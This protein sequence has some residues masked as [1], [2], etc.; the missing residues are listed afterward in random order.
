MVYLGIGNNELKGG[1]NQS[2]SGFTFPIA[3]ATVDIDGKTIVRNGQLVSTAVASAPA[4]KKAR[5]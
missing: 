2:V 4:R 3:N 5:K 1:K